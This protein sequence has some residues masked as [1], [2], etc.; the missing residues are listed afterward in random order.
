MCCFL[1]IKFI[2]N[3]RME[4]YQFRFYSELF[5][6]MRDFIYEK[7][8]LIIQRA[9][10][11]TVRRLQLRLIRLIYGNN[12]GKKIKEYSL[13]LKNYLNKTN[14]RKFDAINDLENIRSFYLFF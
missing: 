4:F 7:K 13:Q 3:C 10:Y 14:A 8:Q 5:N 12:S 2:W 1:N 11:I 9:I 6:N